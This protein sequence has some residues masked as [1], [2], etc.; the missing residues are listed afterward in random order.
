MSKRKTREEWVDRFV[1]IH[2]SKYDY[3]KAEFKT[4]VDKIS[5]GCCVHG[6]FTQTPHDHARGRGCKLCGY[7]KSI[8]DWL[9]DFKMVHGDLY[10]YTNSE[11]KGFR[12]KISI[13][14]SKHGIFKQSPNAHKSG[15]GCPKCSIKISDDWLDDF[16]MVHGDLYDY[17]NSEFKGGRVKI[18]IGCNKHG[19]FKQTP[20]SHRG[21]NGCPT[22]SH[23]TRTA[24]LTKPHAIYLLEFVE[25]HGDLYD[26]KNS[27]ITS[28]HNP[29]SISCSKHGV[30]LQSPH[31]HKKGHGC[32]TCRSSKGEKIVRGILG[33]NNIK[34][35]EQKRF[36]GCVNR[37]CL[38]FDFYTECGK[39]IE[40]QGKQHR[41]SVKHFG[42]L[43]Q[44]KKQQ[45]N[46]AIKREYCKTNNIP[47]LEVWFDDKDPEQT[48]KDF[49]NNN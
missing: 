35:V 26:Y 19:I 25:I 1:E 10:D 15:K 6:N 12:V 48:I 8:S 37:K 7:T 32:P 45:R 2:G 17:T 31:N 16:K 24:V 36:D 33:D 39:L 9:D 40:Y 21:G 20:T 27:D 29:I 13:G 11:F 3:S 5:I 4:A 43:D 30:F 47:L 41:E 34:F 44:L 23:I 49:L 46:D 14:C 18:S 28:S 38:P 22:C 42:G